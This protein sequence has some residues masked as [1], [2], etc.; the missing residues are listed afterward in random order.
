MGINI[1]NRIRV[2][3]IIVL[4]PLL[5]D[6]VIFLLYTSLTPHWGAGF[7][8]RWLTA[9]FKISFKTAQIIVF[10]L[11]KNLHFW[12]YGFLGL[13]FWLYFFLWR[14]KKPLFWGII[15]SAGVA[16]LDEYVQSRTSFRTGRPSDVFLDVC[17]VVL[18]C[19]PVYLYLKRSKGLI[20]DIGS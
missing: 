5:S 9:N 11:R 17:G 12:G 1:T 7:W 14:F 18:V 16:V 20:V 2:L 6:I 8:E 3:G 4:T 19:F 15:A 13:L 10:W